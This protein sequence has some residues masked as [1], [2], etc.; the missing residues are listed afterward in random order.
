VK[1]KGMDMMDE[2][3]QDMMDAGTHDGLGSQM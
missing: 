1:V 2:V 3:K